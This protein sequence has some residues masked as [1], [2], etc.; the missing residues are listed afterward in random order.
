MAAGR[1]WIV[2]IRT[3]LVNK[4]RHIYPQWDRCVILLLIGY[5]V[6]LD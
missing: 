5:N 2:L 6:R 3:S 1:L 4:L